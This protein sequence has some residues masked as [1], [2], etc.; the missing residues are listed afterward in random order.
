MLS[1]T[2]LKKG[3]VIV[4]RNEPHEVLDTNFLRMQQRKAVVQTKLKNLRSG[5]VLTHNFQPSDDIEE[6]EVERKTAIFIYEN[7]GVCWFHEPGNKANRFSVAKERV[8]EQAKFLKPNSEV[9]I[10]EFGGEIIKVMLPI[11]IDFRVTEA[12]PAVR[13][14][15]A[16]GGTKTV[17][18]EGGAKVVTPMFIEQGDIIRINTETG[19]YTERVAKKA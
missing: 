1:Y 16:Q 15:T 3:M 11:K 14:N 8:G 6:A 19:E 2:D 17:T 5:Q 4:W 18:I 7:R 9:T 10:L 12:P 13:G